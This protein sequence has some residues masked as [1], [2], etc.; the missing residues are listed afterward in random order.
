MNA[1]IENLILTVVRSAALFVLCVMLMGHSSEAKAQ[2]QALQPGEYWGSDNCAGTWD[3]NQWWPSN[4]CRYFAHGD[5][6]V[7]FE[8][9]DK[10]DFNK[11]VVHM[12]YGQV[13]QTGYVFAYTGWAVIAI[14]WR[15]SYINLLHEPASF[16]FRQ[17]DGSWLTIPQMQALL[18]A[19]LADPEAAGHIIIGGQGINW[20]DPAMRIAALLDKANGI[21][22]Y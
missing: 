22:D 19:K 7:M 1:T 12:D 16:Y 21:Q 20:D 17:A 14:P 3:G 8:Q 6:E 11:P 4:I 5:T 15:G 18:A 10:S 9:Y 2:S 13:A